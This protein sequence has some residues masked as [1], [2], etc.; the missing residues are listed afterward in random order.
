MKGY[1]SYIKKE[2]GISE[3]IKVIQKIGIDGSGGFFS[4]CLKN[5]PKR[6]PLR[7]PPR[8]KHFKSKFKDGGVKKLLIIGIVQDI[9]ETYYNAKQILRL[10][11]IEKIDFVIATD[12]KRCNIL[13]G[14]LSHSEKF[15][16]PYCKVPYNGFCDHR[17]K[18]CDT[19]LRTLGDIQYLNGKSKEHCEF[20][21]PEDLEA[22]KKDAQDF[23]NCI[24]EPLFSLPDDTLIWDI[25]SLFELHLRLGFINN[26]VTNLNDKWSEITG[27]SDPFWKFCDEN[28][29]KKSTYRGNE[30]PKHCYC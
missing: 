21:Y 8:K 15:R 7:S 22:G 30:V 26:L 5:I 3:D 17:R 13:L 2:R 11:D 25:L 6:N 12:Y 20:S 27:E 18:V 4:V 23:Y 29:I 9:S 28:G 16:C 19:N 10:L 24:E 1:T 14:L